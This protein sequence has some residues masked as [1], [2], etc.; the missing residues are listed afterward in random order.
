MTKRAGKRGPPGAFGIMVSGSRPSKSGCR[1]RSRI[2][3]T[4][5]TESDAAQRRQSRENQDPRPSEAGTGHPAARARRRQPTKAKI[6]G[7]PQKPKNGEGRGTQASISGYLAAV[8]F[9]RS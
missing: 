9:Q 2:G 3:K 6:P 8:N 4:F 7:P 5:A 1:E